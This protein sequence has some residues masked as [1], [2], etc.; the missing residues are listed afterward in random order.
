MSSAH[1]PAS[2]N[3][4]FPIHPFVTILFFCFCN[5][6]HIFFNQNYIIKTKII[7]VLLWEFSSFQFYQKNSKAHYDFF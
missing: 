6:M 1:F 7:I 4:S 2:S 3:L 5:S